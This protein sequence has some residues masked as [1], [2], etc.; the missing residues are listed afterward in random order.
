MTDLQASL[1]IHQLAR[2]EASLARREEIWRRYDEAFADL[3]LETPPPAAPG[4]RHARHLYTVQ[5]ETGGCLV[6]RD[7]FL[8]ALHAE[9]IGTGVH[10]RSIPEHA[11]YR[12]RLGIRSG[13]FPI[14]EDIGRRTLS[15]PLSPAL[16]DGD[17]EDVVQAVRRVASAYSIY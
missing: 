17:V 13:E 15:L 1:G 4:T 11:F 10:Y 8:A 9:G 14:A 16:S 2:V 7:R 12:E 6:S 5:V 3:P